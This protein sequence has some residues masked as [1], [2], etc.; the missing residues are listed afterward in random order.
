MGHPDVISAAVVTT[1]STRKAWVPE[2][3]AGEEVPRDEQDGMGSPKSLDELVAS[4]PPSIGVKKALATLRVK[5]GEPLQT[6]EGT[7]R[8]HTG[9]GEE[10]NLRTVREALLRRKLRG[11][12]EGEESVSTDRTPPTHLAHHPPTTVDVPHAARVVEG[13]E[14]AKAS[15]CDGAALA[16]EEA[17]ARGAAKRAMEAAETAR[18]KVL[19]GQARAARAAGAVVQGTYSGTNK[20][21]APFTHP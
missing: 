12:Q 13:N 6:A 1:P 10:L 18:R 9:A 2:E 8:R 11:P 3:V 17:K 19:A 16:L 4:L 7:W 5:S 20:C 21:R 15:T 14:A